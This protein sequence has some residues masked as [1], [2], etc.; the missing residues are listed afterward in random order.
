MMAPV[1]RRDTPQVQSAEVRMQGAK[2]RASISTSWY[3][4]QQ[5]HATATTTTTD[6]IGPGQHDAISAT[7]VRA[8]RFVGEMRGPSH[9]LQ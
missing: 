8:S 9:K 5:K 4:M 2:V 1:E 3:G 7:C 6:E